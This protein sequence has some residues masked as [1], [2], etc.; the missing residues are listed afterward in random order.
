MKGHLNAKEIRVHFGA[1]RALDGVSIEVKPGTITGLIGPNGSGKTT[2]LNVISGL[3]F[4]NGGEILLEGKPLTGLTAAARGHSGIARTFQTIRLFDTLSV[5][6]NVVLGAHRLMKTSL[7]AA[8]LHLPKARREFQEQC[9]RAEEML[10]VFGDRLLPRL[11]HPVATLSYA[12]RRR[13]EISRALMSAPNVLLLDEPM[14]GMNP[15]ETWELAEQIPELMHRFAGSVL[16]IEHK[17]DVITELCSHVFVLD[18]GVCLTGGT[19]DEIQSH[20]AVVEA[21]LGVE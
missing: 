21:F 15:N 14:A 17:I 13:V 9:E 12:N 18:H 8:A 11:D 20:P 19:P 4:A 7:I 2:L 6:D 16:L 1:L 3:Q 5:L 10:D